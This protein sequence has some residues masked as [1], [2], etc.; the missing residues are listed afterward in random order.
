MLQ[1]W[2]VEWEL[3][4]SGEGIRELREIQP[5]GVQPLLEGGKTAA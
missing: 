1:Q 5:R 4:T 2:A 3:G